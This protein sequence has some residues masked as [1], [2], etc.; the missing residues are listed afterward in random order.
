MKYNNN[1]YYLK[2]NL[3]IIIYIHTYKII[4]IIHYINIYKKLLILL[5]N[6]LQTLIYMGYHVINS[7]NIV[8]Y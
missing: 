1:N 3:I 4:Y 7:D 2:I 8:F 6:Y 5:T